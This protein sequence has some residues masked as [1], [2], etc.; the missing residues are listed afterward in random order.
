[1]A[2][3]VVRINIGVIYH[4]WSFDA[5]FN[6]FSHHFTNYPFY[7]KRKWSDSIRYTLVKV[8]SKYPTNKQLQQVSSA[9]KH[10]KARSNEQVQK[11]ASEPRQM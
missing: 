9:P 1:M 7:S 4:D 11:Q 6:I 3:N 10:A 5:I 8:S 2:V